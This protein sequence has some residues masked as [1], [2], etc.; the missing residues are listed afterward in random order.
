MIEK[1]ENNDAPVFENVNTVNNG[2]QIPSQTL[3]IIILGLVF[4]V[5]GGFCYLHLQ[6]SIET[7]DAY[8][9]KFIYDKMKNYKDAC[10]DKRNINKSLIEYLKQQNISVP[11]QYIIS[12]PCTQPDLEQANNPPQEKSN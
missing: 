10:E 2:S 4:L 7:E 9:F 5:V 1:I 11:P 8:R 6:H 12:K 3:A